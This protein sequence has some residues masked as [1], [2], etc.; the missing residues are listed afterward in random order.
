MSDRQTVVNVNLTAPATGVPLAPQP[1][2]VKTVTGVTAV[3][4][5]GTGRMTP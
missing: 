1:A 4:M 2:T 5:T 3:G